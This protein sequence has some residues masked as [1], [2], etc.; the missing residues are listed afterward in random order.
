MIFNKIQRRILNDFGEVLGEKI[1][2]V[3][4]DFLSAG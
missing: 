3:I 1:F 4:K 2:C